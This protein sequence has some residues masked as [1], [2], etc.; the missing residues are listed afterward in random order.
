MRSL[1]EKLGDEDLKWIVEEA[2]Q[3]LEVLKARE[4]GGGGD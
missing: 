3:R 4:S 1:L 2:K